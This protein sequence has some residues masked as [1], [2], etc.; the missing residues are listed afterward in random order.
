MPELVKVGQVSELPAGASKVYTIGDREVAVFNIA[1]SLYAVDD[2]CPHSGASLGLG[3]VAGNV[4]TC[5]WHAWEFDISSGE[6]VGRTCDPLRRFA[7]AIEG[8][9]LLLDISLTA[10]EE[11]ESAGKAVHSYLVR[12]GVMGWVARFGSSE[13]IDCAHGDWVVIQ[14]LRGLEIGEVL[15]ATPNNNRKPVTEPLS[16][17]LLRVL[18]TDEERLH[19]QKCEETQP[20][21][22]ACQKLLAERQMPVDVIDLEPLFDQKTIV[23]YYLGQPSRELESFA[24]E[25]GQT[26]ST[27]IVFHPVIEPVIEPGHEG[28]GCGS[29]GCGS[30][31]CST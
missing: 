12:Y 24:T 7:V 22:D 23:L 2:R 5:P 13:W 9:D 20:V 30:G 19:R 1:G 16:G 31:G 6:C 29:G 14:T 10:E 8:D 3:S 27:S 15:A 18:S 21:L 4:V 26:R 28:G 25:F 17:D 11:A